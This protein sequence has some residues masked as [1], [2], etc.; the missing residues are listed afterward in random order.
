MPRK[1][2]GVDLP[3]MRTVES[4]AQLWK[5]I[6]A[7][8]ID[9]LVLDIIIIAPF[10]KYFSMPAGGIAESVEFLANNPEVTQTLKI[11]LFLS[12]I[13]ALLYFSIL[14]SRIGQ[15]LGKYIFKIYVRSE[16]KKQL[17]FW[18]VLLSNITLIPFFPFIILW[19]VDPI[20]MFFSKN[21]QRLMEKF[22]KIITVQKYVV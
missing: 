22:T 18:K 12:T 11:I 14:E 16:D 9:I 15:T 7:F 13:L 19:I 2:R 17:S 6:V 3:G 8:F 10:R 1:K 4:G 20:H 21:N 5:R